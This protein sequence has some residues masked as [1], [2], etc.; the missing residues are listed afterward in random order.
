MKAVVGLGNPGREYENTPHSIGFEVVEHLCAGAGATLKRS[1]RFGALTARLIA[2]GND[3]LLVEPQ[4][5]MNASGQAVS[6]IL[7]YYKIELSGLIVV[8]DDADLETG[9]IRIKPSGSSGGHKGLRSVSESVGTDEF[10]RVRIGV[11]RGGDGVDLV[12]HVLGSFSAAERHVMDEVVKEAAAA[13]LSILESGVDRAMNEYN[14]KRIG[15]AG[16]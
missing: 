9:R 14:A 3:V 11:G 8:L 7:H 1:L 16:S 5:Y 4:S 2:Q 15:G 10:V 12:R 13:V 6:A